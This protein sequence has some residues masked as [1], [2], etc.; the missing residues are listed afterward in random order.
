MEEWLDG[1]FKN[2]YNI[3]NNINNIAIIKLVLFSITIIAAIVISKLFLIYNNI[4]DICIMTMI[5]TTRNYI[6]IVVYS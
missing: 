5:Y 2:G 4:I 1:E 6:K 3:N